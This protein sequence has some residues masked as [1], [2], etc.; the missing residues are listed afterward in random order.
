MGHLSEPWFVVLVGLVPLSIWWRGRRAA[1]A[2]AF[3]PAPLVDGLS[4]WRSRLI[5]VPAVLEAAGLVLLVVA[6]ARPVRAERVPEPVEG[7]DIL[8]ALD[9]SS[10]M[11]AQD[12]DARRTRLDVARD[13]AARFV[14]A[15][16]DDRIGIV[17]FARFPDLVCPPT[18]DHGALATFLEGTATVESDGEEDATAIGAAVAKA[19]QVLDTA[20]RSRVVILL[21]DGDENVAVS[22]GA[23]EIAPLHAAQL[24]ERMGVRVHTIVAGPD[25]HTTA[26]EVRRLSERTGGRFFSAKDAGALDGVYAEIDGLERLSTARFREVLRDRFLP[27]LLAGLVLVLA[28][29]VLGR[30][31][32]EVSP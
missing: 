20:S 14:A 3:A 9:V 1:P 8:L 19:V 4:S 30:T 13:A 22:G 7:I 24:A 16:A 23:D 29:R 6:L 28:G 32:L 11:S 12:M 5:W 31:V 27:W 10:S 25:A 26:G 15:R 21:T 18:L 17:R 2:V